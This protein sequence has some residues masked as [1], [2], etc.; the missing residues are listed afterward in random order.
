[1]LS[2]LKLNLDFTKSDTP[3]D[4]GTGRDTARSWLPDLWRLRR[5]SGW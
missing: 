5:C 2:A 1:M 3:L 4:L